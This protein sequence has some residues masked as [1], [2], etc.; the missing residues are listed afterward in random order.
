MTLMAIFPSALILPV[1]CPYRRHRGARPGMTAAGAVCIKT[2]ERPMIE[3]FKKFALRGNAVDLAIGAII[4]AAFGAIG[5]SLVADILSRLS[6][7]LP[8]ASTSP[9]TFC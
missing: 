6:A 9:I 1:H 3:E 5:N 2:R 8:A 4:G 7:R